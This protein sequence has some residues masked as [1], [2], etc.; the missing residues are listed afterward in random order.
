MVE[1]NDLLKDQTAL[2]RALRSIQPTEKE[3]ARLGELYAAL[4]GFLV[5]RDTGNRAR[6]ET[7]YQCNWANAAMNTG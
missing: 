4:G 3:R 5:T 1:F 7:I 6:G 2:M